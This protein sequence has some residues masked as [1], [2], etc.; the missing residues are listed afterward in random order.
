MAKTANKGAKKIMEII[1]EYPE[2]IK[3]PYIKT[4]A[5]SV[6]SITG[7]IFCSKKYDL[8]EVYDATKIIDN[9]CKF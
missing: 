5:E 7:E 2:I 8:L 4:W 3:E 1:G 9:F 6:Q